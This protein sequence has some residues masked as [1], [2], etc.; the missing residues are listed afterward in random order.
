MAVMRAGVYV[1]A[2]LVAGGMTG[3]LRC[4]CLPHL[5]LRLRLHDYVVLQLVGALFFEVDSHRQFYI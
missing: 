5:L 2:H 4:S 3:L 1:L